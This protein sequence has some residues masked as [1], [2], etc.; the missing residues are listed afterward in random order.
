MRGQFWALWIK[1]QVPNSNQPSIWSE[2]EICCQRFVL[3]PEIWTKF[4]T[5]IHIFWILDSISCAWQWCM[6][7]IGG[8]HY[9]LNLSHQ[10][11]VSLT[12]FLMLIWVRFFKT[13]IQKKLN[14]FGYD[15][16]YLKYTYPTPLRNKVV[17]ENICFL[18][19]IIV[20]AYSTKFQKMPDFDL[21]ISFI[22]MSYRIF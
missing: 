12:Q 17:L 9:L 20:D 7:H 11:Y 1:W 8:L 2:S 14:T 15:P 16:G 3:V 4:L 19:V 10:C 22:D 13:R 6:K 5:F 18:Y 21:Y